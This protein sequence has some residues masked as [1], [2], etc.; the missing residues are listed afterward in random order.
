M[1]FRF[2]VIS[3]VEKIERKFAVF[4]KLKD[5]TN[6]NVAVGEFSPVITA[7]QPKLLQFFKLG[8]NVNNTE[9]TQKQTFVRAEGV[10]NPDNSQLYKG[11]MGIIHH[12]KFK[13][14]IQSRR[15]VIVA[16]ALLVWNRL[17]AYLVYPK[18]KNRPFVMAGIWNSFLDPI[19]GRLKNSYAIITTVANELFR[20]LGQDRA[21]LILNNFKLRVWM[22]SRHLSDVV[23]T[24]QPF[25]GS[26]FNAYPVD[27][28]IEN[29]INKSISFL[30]PIGPKLYEEKTNMLSRLAAKTS[31]RSR[32]RGL[33]SN[34]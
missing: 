15:C 32:G 12:P 1:S 30:Q 3:Q 14:A 34:K 21:P 31:K 8:W 11:A 19:S 2:S 6:S 5:F 26:L 28:G 33:K 7:S 4:S 9:E 18:N 22:N 13:E 23:H 25:D 20:D 24:M 29:P 16:D 27:S 17:N 10:L